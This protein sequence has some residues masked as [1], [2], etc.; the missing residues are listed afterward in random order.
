M[1]P[2]GIIAGP[3]AASA[4]SLP[5]LQQA[6]DNVGITAASDASAGNYDGIG[7]SFPA[8][9]L[10][11]DALAPGRSLLHDGQ[12]ITWPDVAPG[13]PDN[14]LANGQTVAVSGAGAVLGV[15]GASAYGS[16]TGTFTVGYA[17]GSTLTATVTLADWI[18][19]TSREAAASAVCRARAEALP[20]P[21]SVFS[22][23][24]SLLEAV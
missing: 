12:S 20:C 5:T 10:A 22:R 18:D 3:A 14:V 17:D 4:G 6:F 24:T 15:V 9:G 11:A 16:T 23:A 7:D 19:T 1:L 8:A 13:S 21:S 2:L